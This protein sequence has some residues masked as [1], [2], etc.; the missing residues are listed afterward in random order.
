[1]EKLRRTVIVMSMQVTQTVLF[2]VDDA[3]RAQYEV[4]EGEAQLARALEMARKLRNAGTRF[5]T[6]TTV[7]AEHVGVMG[8]DAVV[9]GKLPGGED[10]VW[11]RRHCRPL[12][13]P[14]T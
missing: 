6:T 1:M 13:K 9:D 11:S 8:V 7:N 10:Y 3:G 12:K 2:Y 5:V 14:R 4:Y